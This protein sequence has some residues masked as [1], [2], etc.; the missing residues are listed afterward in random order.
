MENNNE[1][2]DNDNNNAG[3][4]VV[5]SLCA[6]CGACIN[7]CPSGFTLKGNTAEITNPNASCIPIAAQVCP[8]G[9]IQS[10]EDQARQYQNAQGQGIPAHEQAPPSQFYPPYPPYPYPPQPPFAPPNP[11]YPDGQYQYPEPPRYFPPPPPAPE[12]PGMMMGGGR[13]RGFGMG[14]C[15]GRGMGRGTGIQIRQRRRGKGRGMGRQ[16]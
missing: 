9:A 12:R 11:Y 2:K 6:G 14:R 3:W 16:W 13:G 15:M 7:V 5:K 8:R 1:T 10:S 4:K